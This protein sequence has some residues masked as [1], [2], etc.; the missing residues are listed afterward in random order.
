MKR[1]RTITMDPP[2]PESGGG[3]RG[4]QN[5][6]PLIGKGIHTSS[7]TDREASKQAI[8]A[9]ILGS[10]MF[11]PEDDAHLYLW[12]TNNYL[13]WGLWLMQ[14]LGFTY[15]GVIVWVKLSKWTVDP[16]ATSDG[17]TRVRELIRLLLHGDIAGAFRLVVRYGLGQYFRGAH[18]VCLFGVKGSGYAVRTDAKDIPSV[19]VA[20]LG[21]HSAK[22]DAFHEMVR[23]RSAGPYLE[24]FAR[25]TRLGGD[26]WGNEA[27]GDDGEE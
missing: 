5:H 27:P 22:P 6:Y 14:E 21:R 24:V 1:Y 20:P 23:R 12:V 15:K 9:T 3:G 25:D 2:W 11:N 10:G 26:V 4:A 19:I 13:E 17:R 18:E 16:W 7:E 8:K